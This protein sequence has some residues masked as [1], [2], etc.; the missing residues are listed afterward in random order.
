M[1]KLTDFQKMRVITE[2]GEQLGHLRDLRGRSGAKG[3][4][5]QVHALV[6]GRFG[7]L[8]RF[9]LRDGVRTTR[10]WDD[11]IRIEGRDIIVRDKRATKRGLPA[12]HP[13]R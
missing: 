12:K 9:G 3:P 7:W 1:N 2:S 6:Y 11:V 10:D 8:E 5:L 13:P 4:S